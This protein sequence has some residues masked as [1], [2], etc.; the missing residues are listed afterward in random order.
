M[1]IRQSEFNGKRLSL[2]IRFRIG[3][4]QQPG[5]RNIQRPTQVRVTIEEFVEKQVQVL[6]I[7]IP[8]LVHGLDRTGIQRVA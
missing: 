3:D 6:A 7:T 2:G 5:G 8:A 4:C 1:G